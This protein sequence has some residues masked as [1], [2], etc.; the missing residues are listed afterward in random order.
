MNEATPE[1]IA[2]AI[3]TV[4]VLISQAA[5]IFGKPAMIEKI[6]IISLIWDFIAANYGKAKNK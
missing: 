5:A 1:Q 4:I 6:K 2:S 3:T